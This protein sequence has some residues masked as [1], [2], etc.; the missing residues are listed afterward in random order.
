MYNPTKMSDEMFS[1]CIEDDYELEFKSSGKKCVVYD[2][3]A[4]VL[5]SGD[6][7][8]CIIYANWYRKYEGFYPQI[9]TEECYNELIKECSRNTLE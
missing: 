4:T 6:A 2:G 8:H 5:Y 9:S 3:T 1:T 7:E